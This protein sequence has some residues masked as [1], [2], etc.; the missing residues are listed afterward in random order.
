MKENQRISL[1]ILWFFLFC[2]ERFELYNHIAVSKTTGYND[3]KVIIPRRQ[4]H[5]IR[6]RHHVRQHDNDRKVITLVLDYK[7]ENA[8]GG[9]KRQWKRT[10]F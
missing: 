4:A 8:A 1:E 6:R 3:R 7:M 2:S 9:R 10:I 5:K